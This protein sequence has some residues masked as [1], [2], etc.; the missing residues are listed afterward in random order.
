VS[1]NLTPGTRLRS[2][3]DIFTMTKES[4][5]IFSG[6]SWLPQEGKAIFTYKIHHNDESFEFHETLTFPLAQ[7]AKD[8]PEALLKNL[9]DNL[10]LAL[11]ISYYKLFCPKEIVLEGIVLSKEQADFWNTVYTKGLGEFFYQNKIDFRGLIAF[12]VAQTG[13]QS[14]SFSRQDRALVGIGGGKDSIV[15]AE[16]LQK[17]QKPFATFVVN[18]HAVRDEVIALLGVENITVTR[19]IDPELLELNKRPDTYNGH[20][21]VSSHFAFIGLFLGVLYNYRYIVVSNEH[22]AN[23]GNVTYLGMEANHQWSKSFE[24]E[25]MFQDYCKQYI[26]PDVIYFSLLRPLTE[27]A[28]VKQFVTYPKYF[29]HFSSC[30]RNFKI[31]DASNKRW[32]GECPKCA[33]A[34]LLLSAFLPKNQLLEIFG[35]NLFAKESLLQTYKELLGVAAIKPFDCVG[36]PEEVAVAFSLAAQKG[37]YAKDVVMQQVMEILAKSDSIETLKE[38]VFQKVPE[39]RIPKEFEDS[40]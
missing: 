11:G 8:I 6:H 19:Q 13:S 16:L 25:V 28:I 39:H 1:S 22:S 15:S 26:T 12:P 29:S 14:V 34:F 36:T 20:V 10:L 3:G 2:L 4:T 7:Q 23:Y 17:Y 33:F 31:T 21:P 40:V 30:N 24:F 9:L 38:Q 32:C 35:Q 18:Q 5:F 27:I 37:E